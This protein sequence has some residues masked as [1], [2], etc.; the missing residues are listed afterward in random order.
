MNTYYIKALRESVYFTEDF[1]YNNA[2]CYDWDLFS[3]NCDTS[4]YSIDFFKRF[5]NEFK[6]GHLDWKNNVDTLFLETFIKEL[7]QSH[8]ISFDEL[9]SDVSVE[10][11]D[12][13]KFLN[14]K[15]DLFLDEYSYLFD[16]DYISEEF[17]FKINE[18]RKYKDKINFC[19]LSQNINIDSNILLEFKEELVNAY[20]NNGDLRLSSL[21]D[22]LEYLDSYSPEFAE[23]M[24]SLFDSLD[25][26]NMGL[27]PFS[28][29]SRN[30]SLHNSE[31][32]IKKYKK[33]LYL[34]VILRRITNVKFYIPIEKDLI[35]N[36]IY[37]E[38]LFWGEEKRKIKDGYYIPDD[39]VKDYLINEHFEKRLIY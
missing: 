6:F 10:D 32:F 38:G 26:D 11:P 20:N 1:I 17:P 19:L 24:L 14:K 30:M 37:S 15:R 21:C 39:F 9:Y 31:W 12:Y 23:F 4:K 27:N 2:D 18:V 7:S 22:T 5:K 33:E 29:I 36:G 34:K 13:L 8:F 28:G 16:W 3:S 25:F 35:D